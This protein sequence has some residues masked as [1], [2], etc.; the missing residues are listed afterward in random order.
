MYAMFQREA[1]QKHAV[2]LIGFAIA[3]PK[4]PKSLYSWE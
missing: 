1:M 2:K 3:R 4:A